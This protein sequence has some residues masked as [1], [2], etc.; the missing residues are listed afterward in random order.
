[1]AT[2]TAPTSVG[3][4]LRAVVA[5]LLDA[6]AQALARRLRE[7][8]AAEHDPAW[9]MVSQRTLPEWLPAEVFIEACRAGKIAGA[10]KWHRQWIARRDAVMEWVHADGH[11]VVHSKPEKMLDPESAE[12]ILAANGIDLDP[13]APRSSASTRRSH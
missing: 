5:W 9:G 1:M 7:A 8:E 2:P 12:G 6:L 11:A 3:V 10:V 4:A 13:A